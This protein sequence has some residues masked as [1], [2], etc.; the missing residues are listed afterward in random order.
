MNR[1]K[2]IRLK[3]FEIIDGNV[4]YELAPVSIWDDKAEDETNNIYVLLEDQTAQFVE[5]F[6]NNQWDTTIQL[7]I[8]NKQQ[9]TI[10]KD[11]TDDVSE[12]IEGLLTTAL[13]AGVEYEG[14]Q[15][16]NCRL[17]SAQYSTWTLAKSR[18]VVEKILIF[19][20]TLIKL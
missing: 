7:R 4:T 6:C 2:A 5:N 17:E 8:V 12:Q 16:L 14:W 20:Q 19:R 13:V 10:S 18:T 15:I 3:V 11:T 9:D 1:E